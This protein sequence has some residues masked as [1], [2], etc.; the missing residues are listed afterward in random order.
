MRAY[1]YP[2]HLTEIPSLTIRAAQ[3]E[4]QVWGNHYIIADLSFEKPTG[5][6][7]AKRILKKFL[8]QFCQRHRFHFSKVEY[9]G[10]QPHRLGG[11]SS[12]HF[13]LY[14]RTLE[15]K[16]Y[17]EIRKTISELELRWWVL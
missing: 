1:E 9:G 13:H 6:K 8:C 17:E 14:M 15:Q 7:E 4:K 3:A 10:F 12:W 11:K 2:E 5:K 16:S